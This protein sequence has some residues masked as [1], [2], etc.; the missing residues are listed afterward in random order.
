MNQSPN[1]HAFGGPTRFCLDYAYRDSSHGPRRTE[2]RIQLLLVLLTKL[3][4]QKSWLRT[5]SGFRVSIGL[6]DSKLKNADA[7]RSR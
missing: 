1:S 4:L 3:F 6:S 7:G 2:Q 5:G